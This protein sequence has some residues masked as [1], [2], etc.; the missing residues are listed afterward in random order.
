MTTFIVHRKTGKPVKVIGADKWEVR[1]GVLYFY[2]N[3]YGP[4]GL[5]KYDRAMSM[6]ADGEWTHTERV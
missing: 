4:E 3:Q 1:G 2:S 5:M 6:F